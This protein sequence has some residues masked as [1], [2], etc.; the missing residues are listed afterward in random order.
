MITSLISLKLKGKVLKKISIFS[1]IIIIF[2]FCGCSSNILNISDL[3]QSDIVVD[4]NNINIKVKQDT[5]KSWKENITLILENKTGYECFYGVDFTLE[6]EL[7]EIWYKV[8][9]NKDYGFN[10]IGLILKGNSESEE[11]IELSKYF[12]NLPDGKYRIVKSFYVKDEKIDSVG[13]F[14]IK[15]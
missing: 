8:P 1:L 9:F 10:E 6:V 2:L 11:T 7:D 13:L 4:C 5:I 3:E 12:S 15:K 14:N